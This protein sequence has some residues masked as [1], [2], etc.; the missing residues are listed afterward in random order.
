MA[1]LVVAGTIS[2]AA[3][4]RL[5]AAVEPSDFPETSRKILMAAL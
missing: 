4:P 1:A 3:R 2:P 5:R